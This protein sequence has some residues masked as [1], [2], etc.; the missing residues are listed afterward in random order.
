MGAMNHEYYV[1]GVD[2][3]VT[4]RRP[5]EQGGIHTSRFYTKVIE[6]YLV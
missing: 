3:K 2:S 6:G 5:R 1:R 4:G